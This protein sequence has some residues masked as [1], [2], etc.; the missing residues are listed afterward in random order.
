MFGRAGVSQSAACLVGL[1][2]AITPRVVSPAGGAG[3]R[4]PLSMINQP[5]DE[6][7]RVELKGQMHRA[8]RGSEDLGDADPQQL[9]E[10]IIMLLHGGAAQ[11]ADLEQFLKDVQT[12]GGP[13][14][15]HWLNPQTF[16]QRFGVATA[17]IA[18]IRTWLEAKGFRIDEEP[19]GGRSIIF[20]GSIGQLNAA[21]ATRIHRYRWRGESHLANAT[22]PTIPKALAGVVVGFASLHD[23]RHRPQHSGPRIRPQYTSGGTHYLGPGDFA[24]I[25]D[26]VAPYAQGITGLG[27]SIAVIGRSSVQSVDLSDFRSFFALSSTMPIIIN[28]NSKN[29]APP[30]VSGD[31]TES[32][33][34]LEWSGAV[35]PSATIKFVTTASTMLS[36]GVDLASQWAVSKNL[37]DV[38]SLSY[39]SCESTGDLSGGT[40]LYNQLWQQAAAQGSS[41][42]VSSGDSGAAG[43]D[44]DN[45]ATATQGL[46]VNALCSSPNSTCVGGTQFSA[47]VSNPGTYWGASN[48]P[49][50]QASA[51]SYIPE[52]VW[53]QS[54]SVA[55]GAGLFASGGGT[56]IYFAKPAW[57]LAT[58]VPSDGWRDVPDLALNASGAH[59]GY[60]IFSSDGHPAGTLLSVG[61]TSA[62]A[63]SM[64]GFAALILQSQNG[65]VGNFNPVLYG[66]SGL[67]VNGGARVFHLITSGNNSVPGQPG[68][69]AST[70]DPTYNQA[71]G[72]GSIDGAQL[73]AHWGDYVP[74]TFGLSP[75]TAVVPATAVIG[76]ASLTLPSTTAWSAVVGGGG[77]GWLSV[78]PTSGTGSA[79]LT[80]SATANLGASARSGTISVVGQ[81]LT[82]TQA[83]A[84]GGTAQVNL[85]TSALGFG[86]DPLG[87]STSSQLVLVSDTG[88]ANL[89]LGAIS[90]GGG[91][92][93]D[94]SESGSCVAGLVLTPGASCYLN[95]TFDPTAL[96]SRAATLQIGISGGG[97]V[98]VALSGTGAPD[99]GGSDGPMPVWAYALLAILLWVIAVR[100]Q[101]AARSTER[102]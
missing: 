73:I 52:A 18:L 62:A 14:Y 38:I 59:D 61:G 20:S 37:A 71:A 29:Q 16:A 5:I 86:V 41:V 94:F 32:D 17:D 65:R 90:L 49:G 21:F 87:R 33:L 99:E 92:P 12:R 98:S 23:F 72:L 6:S 100:R 64:A 19:A 79:P 31:E 25:Y 101:R 91:A 95:V 85:S 51:L 88:S 28:A 84:S 27:R 55:G 70:T 36:D 11:D 47:D 68:F 10:R 7:Q 13:E 8:V 69:S 77:A 26:L 22:S 78:A 93:G 83:A 76:S 43:C 39:G 60:L 48:T 80:Y 24:T 58:G 81:V 66:L 15:H 4:L 53:N 1:A 50:T 3:S 102:N 56:S 2:L 9:T 75:A 45:S 54:G 57:Q 89:T 34:D 63:P 74:S 42:F 46:A 44:A 96:G 40:T 97:S 67:Q 82:V 35:A 30:L